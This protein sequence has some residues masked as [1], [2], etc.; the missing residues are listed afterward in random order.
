MTSRLAA[1]TARRRALQAECEI[2]RDDVRLLY[3]GIEHR[4]ARVDQVVETVRDL[5][6]VIAIGGVVVMFALGPRR[7]LSLVRRGLTIAL[8]ANQA[9]HTLLGSLLS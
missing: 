8:Y 3:A 1:L 7:V 6:P 2:Q 5:A 9:R 4:T